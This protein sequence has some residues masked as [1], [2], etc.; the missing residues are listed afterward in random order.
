MKKTSNKAVIG[1]LNRE[2]GNYSHIER[3][4]YEDTNGKRYVKINGDPTSISWLITHGRTVKVYYA[5]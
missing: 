5:E 4:V 2:T 3:R 1:Q